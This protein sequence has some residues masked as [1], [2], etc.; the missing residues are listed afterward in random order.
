MKLPLKSCVAILAGVITL[1]IF[2]NAFEGNIMRLVGQNI[3]LG[4]YSL[5]WGVFMITIYSG[6][7]ASSSFKKKCLQSGCIN[8]VVALLHIVPEVWKYLYVFFNLNYHPKYLFEPLGATI[9][10]VIV[11]I[12]LVLTGLTVMQMYSIQKTYQEAD[13]DE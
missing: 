9:V 11:G 13:T 4:G 7:P 6:N 1:A 12:G 2:Q 5:T 8:I 10:S 3:L